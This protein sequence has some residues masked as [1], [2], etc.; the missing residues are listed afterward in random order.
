MRSIGSQRNAMEMHEKRKGDQAMW[1]KSV[2]RTRVLCLEPEGSETRSIW[3]MDDAV[4]VR[5]LR[6]AGSGVEHCVRLL[7]QR[8]G[9]KIHD[10][11]VT[12]QTARRA[13]DV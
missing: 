10:N 12:G 1:L 7:E 8:T 4:S 13:V 3:G 6:T 5:R 2:C 11:E 9:Q